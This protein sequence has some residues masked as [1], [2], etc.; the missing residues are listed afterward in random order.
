MMKKDYWVATEDTDTCEVTAFERA[1]DTDVL[2]LM[3]WYKID[4]CSPDHIHVRDVE[5][6]QHVV[7]DGVTYRG[8]FGCNLWV[9]HKYLE[10]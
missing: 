1:D 2:Y 6:G 3:D 8:G 4:P 7:Y 10:V 5:D 9:A